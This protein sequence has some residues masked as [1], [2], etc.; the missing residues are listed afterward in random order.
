ML[1]H[2]Y[3]QVCGKTH[4][5]W[6]KLDTIMFCERCKEWR[7]IQFLHVPYPSNGE[8]IDFDATLYYDVPDWVKDDVMGIQNKNM[9]DW[10]NTGLSKET[11][12]WIN[13]SLLNTEQYIRLVLMEFY[14][15]KY[16]ALG[17]FSIG[18]IGGE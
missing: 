5:G 7:S 16:G 13:E 6:K 4:D 3:C 2:F 10:E 9:I 12:R 14:L 8:H 1:G 15:N 17:R 18:Y 11:I